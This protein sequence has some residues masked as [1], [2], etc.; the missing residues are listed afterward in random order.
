MSSFLELQMNHNPQQ[1]IRHCSEILL[2]KTQDI[3][4]KHEC[5]LL[6]HFRIEGILHY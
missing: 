6:L 5:C 3:A 2:L 4:E 1:N